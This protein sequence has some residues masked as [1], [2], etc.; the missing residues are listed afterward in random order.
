[1]KEAVDRNGKK[2][3]MIQNYLNRSADSCRDKYRECSSDYEKGRW[4]EAE[5][6]KLSEIVRDH[7]KA[8]PNAS[9]VEIGKMV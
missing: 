3:V 7:L 8:D 6:V 5:V 1:M 4:N 9:M 2:W